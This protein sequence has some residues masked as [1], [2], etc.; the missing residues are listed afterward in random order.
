MTD[1]TT[2]DTTMGGMFTDIPAPAQ[3]VTPAP[4]VDPAAA[5]PEPAKFVVG[6]RS[7]K[8]AEEALAYANGLSEAQSRTQSSLQAPAPAESSSGLKLGVRLFEDPDAAID[9]IINTAKQQIRSEDKVV[10]ERRK[11]WDDFYTAHPDLR[12]KELMV[13]AV[14][15]REREK[16][17][18]LATMEKYEGAPILAARTREYFAKVTNAPSGGQQLQ[19]K[20]AIV[21]GGSGQ[22]PA[23]PAPQ[24]PA[25]TDFI[26]ELRQM[27]KR[28]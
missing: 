21:A 19:S 13:E 4:A 28:G 22:A 10:D 14:L 11:F 7:F 16:G 18:A 24:T 25:P 15:G 3:A 9:E 1:T 6:S 26:T 2:P 8:S 20:P 5:A 12:G 17:S 23:A 27:R